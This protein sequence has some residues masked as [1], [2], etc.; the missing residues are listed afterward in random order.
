M[1][2]WYGRIMRA[3]AAT[4]MAMKRSTRRIKVMPPR[5]PHVDRGSLGKAGALSVTA[6]LG[7]VLEG[8]RPSIGVVPAVADQVRLLDA[9]HG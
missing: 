6:Q 4:F 9:L 1:L 7:S 8:K 3:I 2:K 5:T